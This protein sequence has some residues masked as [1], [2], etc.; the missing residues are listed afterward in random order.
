MTINQ[1]LHSWMEVTEVEEFLREP[2][3]AF[4][5]ELLCSGYRV[6]SEP[7]KSLVLIDDFESCRGKIVFQK[8]LGREVKMHNLWEYTSMRKS[9]LTKRIYL[10]MSACEDNFSETGKKAADKARVLKQ[11]VVSI[12]GSNPFI[13][14]QMERG[15]DWTISSVAGESYR[16]DI[17]LTELLESWAAKKLHTITDKPIKVKPVWRDA[18]FTLKYYSDALFD[19]PHWF[20][21]SKR[22][23]NLRLT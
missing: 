19:F 17:D 9:L 3:A 1:V 6:H 20:G 4:S 23:F 18:S 15:L 13:K 11:F 16:V 14:W 10:L 22:K 7:E 8:S 12:D 5:V 2:P 21:F